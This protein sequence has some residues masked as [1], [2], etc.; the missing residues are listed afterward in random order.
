MDLFKGVGPTVSWNSSKAAAPVDPNCEAQGLVPYSETKVVPGLRGIE[1]KK[2]TKCV[3]SD[4][5]TRLDAA[6]QSRFSPATPQSLPVASP[7]FAMSF[8]NRMAAF[9]KGGLDMTGWQAG[10]AAQTRANTMR[11]P[12]FNQRSPNVRFNA[13]AAAAVPSVN[14]A[15][16]SVRNRIRA[17]Q[18]KIGQGGSKKRSMKNKTKK[19]KNKKNKR[20]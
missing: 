20:D 18:Q 5:A 10:L 6:K 15:P 4:E 14:Q 2:V 12:S 3:T 13:P 7:G 11:R 1:K 19:N 17:I 8:K 9:Q 16:M